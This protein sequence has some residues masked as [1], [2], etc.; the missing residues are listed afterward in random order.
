LKSREIHILPQLP[1]QIKTNGSFSLRELTWATVA[2][3]VGVLLGAMLLPFLRF[4]LLVL[5]SSV[6][7]VLY[8]LLSA[9]RPPLFVAVC[10]VHGNLAK[11]MSLP[12]EKKE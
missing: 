4:G 6:R 8:I 3:S 9:N 12:T 2:S 1:A 11:E 7:F 10:G 5:P